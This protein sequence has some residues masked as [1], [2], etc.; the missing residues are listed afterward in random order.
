[1]N[2]RVFL[3]VTMAL[4]PG[5]ATPGSALAQSFPCR[6]IRIVAP[7]PTGAPPDVLARIV[8][9]AIAAAEDWTVVV[10]NKPAPS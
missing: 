2:R 3:I 7:P 5:L 9:N 8:G 4:T 10:E 6:T 1:M